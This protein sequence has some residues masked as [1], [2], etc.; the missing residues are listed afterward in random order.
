MAIQEIKNQQIT[1]QYFDG[2]GQMA[3]GRPEGGVWSQPAT[4]STDMTELAYITKF[5]DSGDI[6]IAEGEAGRFY[7]G[8]RKYRR[9]FIW[10]NKKY[11][12]VL[13]EIVSRSK[14][15]IT[16]L[17]Q[18]P[19]LIEIEKKPDN[20]NFTYQLKNENV[21]CDFKII[22]EKEGNPEIK[23][24]PADSG[25]KILGW[26]QLNLNFKDVGS[27][28]IASVFDIWDEK[29]NIEF[30][31]IDERSAKIIVKGKSFKDEWIWKTAEGLKEPSS[32]KGNINGKEYEF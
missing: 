23:T 18:G 27:M 17:M 12:L 13:D 31:P 6:V 15:N 2:K 21:T 20:K 5:K 19:E 28:R 7:Q 14:S 3:P 32:I 4:G 8:L 26:K 10:V 22:S 30:E 29:V 1:I 25:G 24:S 9:S 11:L 16:Y